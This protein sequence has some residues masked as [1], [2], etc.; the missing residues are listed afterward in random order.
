MNVVLIRFSST[1]ISLASSVF[2]SSNFRRDA[3][4]TFANFANE[5]FLRPHNSESQCLQVF[6]SIIKDRI[7]CPY[8]LTCILFFLLCGGTILL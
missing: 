8:F 5:L 1:F 6:D 2:I 7:S 3:N 4:L